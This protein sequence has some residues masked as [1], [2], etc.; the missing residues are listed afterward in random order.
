VPSR[1]RRVRGAL[2]RT[3]SGLTD[4]ADVLKAADTVLRAALD[5]QG[6][7]WGTVDPATTLSTSCARFGALDTGPDGWAVAAARERRLFELEWA[8]ADPHTFWDLARRRVT[9]AGLRTAAANPLGVRRYDE[10][11]A[12]AGIYDELRVRLAIDDDQWATAILY[13]LEPRPFTPDDVAVAAAAA[14]VIARAVRTALLRAVCDSRHVAAP[15]GSLLL[16]A[17]GQLLVSSAAAEELLADL[18]ENQVSSVLT[19]LAA[20]TR[21]RG[22]T[23]LTVAAPGGVLALHGSAAK[24]GGAAVAAVVERPRPIELAPLIMR[25]FAFTPRERQVTEALLQGASR[26]QLARRLQLSEHTVG[27]HLRTLYRKAGVTGRGELAALLYG[28]HYEPPRSAGVP[29][30]PYG[31]FVGSE[32][33]ARSVR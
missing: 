2:L 18:G 29:P 15:P 6:S 25:A 23:S 7:A 11:L 14:P 20:G 28:R 8:D 24:G 5:A 4:L 10:L 12:P 22:A 19:S 27:D 33:A 16:D 9:A 21:A 32:P 30:G 13:R 31:Y 26:T 17:D 1:S 3:L